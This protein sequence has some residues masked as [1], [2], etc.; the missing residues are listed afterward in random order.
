MGISSGVFHHLCS[1]W[2]WALIR[3]DPSGVLHV[4]AVRGGV[5]VATSL[6]Q[7]GLTELGIDASGVSDSGFTTIALV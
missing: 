3:P 4:V 1:A 6:V 7:R 5:Y 2:N